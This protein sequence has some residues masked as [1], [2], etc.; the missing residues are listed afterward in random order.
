MLRERF[1]LIQQ[2]DPDASRRTNLL[3]RVLRLTLAG[4]KRNCESM[5]IHKTVTHAGEPGHDGKE[6]CTGCRFHK[7][8][9]Q[10]V[11]DLTYR[12]HANECSR[13]VNEER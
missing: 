8:S 3:G 1:T 9:F 6:N 10:A 12:G 11:P 2:G 7:G 5:A 4:K 13:N